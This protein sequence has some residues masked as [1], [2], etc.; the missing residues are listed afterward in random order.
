MESY[1]LIPYGISDFA[2][3]REENLYYSD[4]TMFLPRMEAAGHFLFLIRP[5]RFGKSLFLSMMRYYYDILEKDNF[6]SLFSGLW[7][8]KNP[9]PL[10]GEFQVLYLDFSRVGG[11][12]DTLSQSF[13]I[14]CS[15]VAEDFARRYEAFYPPE[16]LSEVLKQKTFVGKLNVIDLYAKRMKRKLYLIVDEY[17]NFTNVVLNVKGEQVYHAMTHSE[18]FYRSVF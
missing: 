12:I 3:V 16:Y 15:A 1:K 11:D 14:Y 2:Q 7:I 5:R 13:D 9:T 4:K 18:G 17:D 10:M 6:S 8:E